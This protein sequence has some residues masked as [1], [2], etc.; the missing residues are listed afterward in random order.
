LQE[1]RTPSK[2]ELLFSDRIA[3][4]VMV[5]MPEAEAVV[6]ISRRADGYMDQAMT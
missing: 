2:K 1:I 4:R 6:Q 5:S 3:L